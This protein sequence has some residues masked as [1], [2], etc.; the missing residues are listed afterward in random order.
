MRQSYGFNTSFP[1]VKA[2]NLII[3]PKNYKKVTFGAKNRLIK[4]EFPQILGNPV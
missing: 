2:K 3:K 1:N 4:G